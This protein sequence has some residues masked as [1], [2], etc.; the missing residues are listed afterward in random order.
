MS[1]SALAL[2]LACTIAASAAAPAAAQDAAATAATAAA[3]TAAA[4]TEAARERTSQIIRFGID[5]QVLETVQRLAAAR[6]AGFNAE[7]AAIL[8]EPRAAGVRRAILELFEAL[9]STEGQSAAKAILAGWQD[10]PADLLVAAMRYLSSIQSEGMGPLVTPLVDSSDNAVA[11]AAIRALG[12]SSDATAA[13]FLLS[14]LAALDFPDARKSDL[15]LAMGDLKDAKT[16][17]ALASIAKS[18]DE[19]KVRRMYA[20]DALGKIGDPRALPVLKDMFVENDA[21]IRAYAAS[22]LARFS[23]DEVFGE[24]ILGLKDENW[25][26]REQCAKSLGR[27]LAPGQAATAVP[28]LSFKAELDPTSQ[29]RLE[30]IRSLGVIDSADARAFLVKVY[31]GSA[32][33]AESRDAALAA[34]AANALASVLD[35]VKAVLAEEWKSYDQKVVEA[36]ARILSTA[37]GGQ[38]KEIYLKLL[39]SSNAAA[40]SYAVRGI[41]GNRFTE[42]KDRVRQVA[43][44][45]PNPATKREAEKALALF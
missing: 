14:K 3:A 28:I 29:V 36:T 35:A 45:D 40:R 27:Q 23:L 39:E 10:A 30:S 31:R 13:A 22:A 9:K 34:L 11:S 18:A 5:S 38:L 1:R 21:L 44:Q 6:D 15:I 17:D 41:A 33:P 43:E 25:K 42:L 19:D 32:Y 2:L 16:V 37:K 7:L 8:A 12:M 24:L 26:V 20:A 4:A